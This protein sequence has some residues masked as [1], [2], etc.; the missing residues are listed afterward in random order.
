MLRKKM[1]TPT[2]RTEAGV[3]LLAEAGG[4]TPNIRVSLCPN[5]EC[6]SHKKTNLL[7]LEGTNGLLFVPVSPKYTKEYLRP[8]LCNFCSS[9]IPL[10]TGN[11][12]AV[13][14]SYPALVGAAINYPIIQWKDVDW[15]VG[16]LC[17]RSCKKQ[18]KE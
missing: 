17:V 7:T 6:M 18:E 14:V 9:T 11:G 8:M 13:L 3:L 1:E 10:P 5:K 2:H 4:W 16:H 15:V 12:W